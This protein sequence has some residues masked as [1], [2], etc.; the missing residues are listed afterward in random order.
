MLICKNETKQKQKAEQPEND[1]FILERLR[2]CRV[3][4]PGSHSYGGEEQEVRPRR[5]CPHNGGAAHYNPYR[6][7]INLHEQKRF[8]FQRQH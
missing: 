2:E 3:T 5:A 8:H 7:Y 6:P 4:S 1:A